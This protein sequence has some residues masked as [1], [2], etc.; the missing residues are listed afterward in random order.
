MSIDFASLEAPFAPSDLEWKCQ[1]C[2]VKNGKPGAM[3]VPYV[4]RDAVMRRLNDVVG[5]GNWQTRLSGMPNGGMVME[6]GI[7]MGDGEWMWRADAADPTS[8]AG[9]ENAAK[10]G[11]SNALKRVASQ[12]GIGAYL[13]RFTRK[14]FGD[15]CNNNRSDARIHCA[16]GRGN[17]RIQFWC[18]PPPL[19]VWALPGG[20]GHP[21]AA[22]ATA[23]P[24]GPTHT[25]PVPAP[26][27]A[28]SPTAPTQKTPESIGLAEQLRAKLNRLVKL[29]ALPKVQHDRVVKALDGG[30]P[31][32]LRT[33][34]GWADQELAK[35]GDNQDG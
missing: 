12:W 34:I 20:S 18:D 21:P 15:N 3:V 31:V 14:F 30:D 23:A 25:E 1:T 35:H 8:G 13:Y 32:K 24:P 16:K 26:G 10:G 5:P 27:V 19:P 9:D 17:E 22:P 29:N 33:W 4:T 6:L 2:W 7:R 11:A 28:G